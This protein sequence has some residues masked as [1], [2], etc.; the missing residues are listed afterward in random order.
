LQLGAQRVGIAQQRRT[1]LD[2]RT[3]ED[4]RHGAGTPAVEQANAE[5]GFQG[6]DVAGIE[7]KNKNDGPAE[8]TKNA[9]KN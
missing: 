4:R 3:P 8:K 1:P 9:V 7:K 2:D 5:V 6:G